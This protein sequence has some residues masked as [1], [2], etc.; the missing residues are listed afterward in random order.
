MPGDINIAALQETLNILDYVTSPHDLDTLI[1][2]FWTKSTVRMSL[3]ALR[4]KVNDSGVIANEV[5]DC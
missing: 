4:G 5:Q 1:L 3:V 2:T